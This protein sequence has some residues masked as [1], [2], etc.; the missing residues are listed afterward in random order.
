MI[1]LENQSV[2]GQGKIPRIEIGDRLKPVEI[3]MNI[4]Q[5]VFPRPGKYEFELLAND[6]LVECRDLWV[7]KPVASPGK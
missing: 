4:R 3:A 6:E 1:D 7:S 2:I 5:L